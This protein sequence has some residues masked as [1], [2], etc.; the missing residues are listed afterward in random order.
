MMR[1][2]LDRALPSSQ[3]PQ[4]VGPHLIPAQSTLRFTILPLPKM[5][6]TFLPQQSS[7]GSRKRGRAAA[8]IDGEHSC[9]QKKKR[10]LRLVLITSRLSPQF[11]YPATNIVNRGSSKIAVWAKQKGLGQGMLRKAAILNRIRCGAASVKKPERARACVLVGN[12]REQRR[13]EMAKLTLTYGSVD[14]H[15]RPVLSQTQSVPPL[16]AVRTGSHFLISG[17]PATSNNPSPTSSSPPLF[18][19]IDDSHSDCRSP[20]EAYAYSSP[21]AQI[22]RKY[23]T[24]PPP[25]PLGLSNYDAFDSEDEIPDPYSHLDE[26]YEQSVPTYEDDDRHDSLFSSSDFMPELQTTA[27][28]DV[29]QSLKSSA[30]T[31]SSPN[32][33]CMRDSTPKSPNFSTSI[34]PPTSP[35]F[36][37]STPVAP[38]SPNL[39]PLIRT[40]SA[41]PDLLSV[42]QHCNLLAGYREMSRKR[43]RC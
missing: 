41:S 15:T 28:T 39:E 9:T 27:R 23:Y 36:A 29:S 26:Q 24:P 40:A 30:T 43:R 3:L 12:S 11:S 20:N 10:R 13:M 2:R 14:T 38:G 35:N 4:P 17:S 7:L 16:A 6:L 37:P 22:P 42:S 32:F 18:D 33:S 34:T 19:P 21:C 1:A 25:S 5:G 8:D 31:A